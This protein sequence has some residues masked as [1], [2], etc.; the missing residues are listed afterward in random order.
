MLE[1]NGVIMACWFTL[2]IQDCWGTLFFNTLIKGLGHFLA[3]CICKINRD[4]C[5]K[6]G[7]VL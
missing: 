3:S 1:V 2:R 4:T 6:Y 7:K 5:I